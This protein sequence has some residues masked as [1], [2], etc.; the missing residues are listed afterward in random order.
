MPPAPAILSKF[1]LRLASVL[2][3]ASVLSGCLS[4]APPTETPELPV[5]A[6]WPSNLVTNSAGAD[7]NTLAWSTY[8]TDPVLQ[9]LLETALHNNRDLRLAALR[10]EEA[11]A[12]FG[13][14][15]SERLPD[16]NLGGQGGRARVPG[17]L[18]ASG[19]S[20]VASEY[21]AEVGLSS[22]ELDLW[23]RVR[24]LETAALQNWLATDAA[25]QAVHLALIVQV[26][27]GYLGLRELDERVAIAQQTV[28]TREESYRIFKRRYDLGATSKLDLTQ[29]QTLLNQAQMLL[30]QLQQA[31][32]SQL[33]SLGLLLGAHPGP[34][35]AHA[36]FDETML[37]AELQAGLP[38]D[39]LSNRPDI[40]AAEH[41][42]RASHA[43]IRSARAAFFPRIA[44]TG[45]LGS[46]SAELSGLFASGSRAWTFLPTVSLPIFDGG[47]RRASLEL[48]E[49]RSNMAVADYEKTIQIAFREVADALS[50]KRWLTEQLTIQ[51]AHMQAQSERAR[52]AHLRYDNGSAAYFEVLDAERDLLNV[53][54]SLVQARRAL[55]SSQVALYAALGG[56]RLTEKSPVQ[57]GATSFPVTSSTR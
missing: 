35:P 19:R 6:V 22:W 37:L 16:F 4:F 57:A 17:D 12:A 13:I 32:A 43:S 14:Q 52:L 46:A 10:T 33:Y 31:R 56:R 11:R 49:V 50:A 41:Q 15:R 28:S 7:A 45:S 24:N 39:L 54:Q 2:L 29:V 25:R 47:R 38:A 9:R 23:G 55:L 34:L 44:L 1:S 5:A 18:N 26:A 21:R 27:D 42:L 30:A 51:R 3:S 40:V 20:Q 8:F 53:Q 48:S 36:A